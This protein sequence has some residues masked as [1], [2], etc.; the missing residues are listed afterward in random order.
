M[1][2]KGIEELEKRA[3]TGDVLAL[4][5]LGEKYHTG[6]GIKIDEEKAVSYYEK[7][8]EAGN[9]RAQYIVGKYFED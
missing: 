2:N 8:A 4:F 9:P 1:K 6:D 7:S 3:E 5:E